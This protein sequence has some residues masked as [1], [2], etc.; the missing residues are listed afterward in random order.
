LPEPC[1]NFLIFI[2]FSAFYDF[3]AERYDNFLPEFLYF[4]FALTKPDFPDFV[5]GDIQVSP[6]SN[7]ENPKT[8]FNGMTILVWA[9]FQVH[10][11]GYLGIPKIKIMHLK[12]PAILKT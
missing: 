11:W 5:F 1:D 10:F 7:F 4:W 9:L 6:K 8:G 3:W 2:F 12:Q